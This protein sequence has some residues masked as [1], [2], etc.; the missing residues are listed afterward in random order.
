MSDLHAEK[1]PDK[2]GNIVTRWVK[3][4]TKSK[5]ATKIPAP[6]SGKLYGEIAVMDLC[7]MLQPM[8]HYDS[9]S[10]IARKAKFI[11]DSDPELFARITKSAQFNAAELDYWE[12]T[13]GQGSMLTA[14]SPEEQASLLN[15]YRSA[16]II[17]PLVKR[18]ADSGGDIKHLAGSLELS[19]VVRTMMKNIDAEQSD[20]MVAAVTMIAYLKDLHNNEM[21]EWGAGPGPGMSYPDVTKDAEF[22]ASRLDEVE[23]LLPEFRAR[24][25]WTR[26]SMELLLNSPVRALSEG[27]L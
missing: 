13:L 22:I 20:E 14:N 11:A 19:R 3:S 18:I 4:F 26:E 12:H 16:F 15:S 24:R 5:P 2:H 6:K 17:N 21:F 25:A 1:R 23:A 8:N 27:E 7:G 9:R 10:L